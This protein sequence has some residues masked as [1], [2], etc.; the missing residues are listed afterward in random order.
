MRLS[1]ETFWKQE[2]QAAKDHTLSEIHSFRSEYQKA[3]SELTEVI[4][5][6]RASKST[7][8]YLEQQAYT[9]KDECQTLILRSRD[10]DAMYEVEIMSMKSEMTTLLVR[11]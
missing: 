4:G 5:H 6:L 2:L 1:R 11:F 3:T 8:E 9:W 10:K 7:L